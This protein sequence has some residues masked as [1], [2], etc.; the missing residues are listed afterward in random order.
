MI[1]HPELARSAIRM[2]VGIIRDRT[3]RP[4]DDAE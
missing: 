2:L 1:D 3:P 4:P